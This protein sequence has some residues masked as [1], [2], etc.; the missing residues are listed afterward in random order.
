MFNDKVQLQIINLTHRTDRKAESISELKKCGITI[1]DESFF[2]AYYKPECGALGCSLSHG[3]LIAHY[4][5]HSSSPYLLVL[6]DDFEVQEYDLFLSNLERIL[7]CSNEWDVFLLGCSGPIPIS[8]I[9]A[10]Q[11]FSRVINSQTS[12]GYI[13]KRSFAVKLMSNFFESALG[14]EHT[15]TLPPKL[16]KFVNH[17]YCLDQLWKG[18]QTEHRFVTRLPTII[19]QRASYSDIEK[20]DV[21]YGV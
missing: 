3:N 19:K 2:E 1:D 21:D 4:L 6:E 16:G 13:V 10:E 9:D 14:L 20:V 15:L 8:L 17:H 7:D 5:S 18:L 11:G 12:S